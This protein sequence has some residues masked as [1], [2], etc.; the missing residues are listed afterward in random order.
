MTAVGV[1][2][3]APSI[4]LVIGPVG[5]TVPERG[6]EVLAAPLAHR[7]LLGL[8]DGVLDGGDG[9]GVLL[10]HDQRSA[11][12]GVGAIHAGRLEQVGVADTAGNDDL[13]RIDGSHS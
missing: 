11:V 9:P 10:G 12:L 13:G 4:R 5:V 8:L 6:L 3:E 2:E 7:V 1:E